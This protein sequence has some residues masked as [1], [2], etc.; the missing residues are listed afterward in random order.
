M[1]TFVGCR[2]RGISTTYI[3]ASLCRQVP[4][5]PTGYLVC[6][7]KLYLVFTE[8][9]VVDDAV[10]RV[11]FPIYNF[12]DV[13]AGPFCSWSSSTRKAATKQCP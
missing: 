2:I 4:V 1:S 13:A 12:V 6:L 8:K 9:L 3:L 5:A 11:G 10:R 7:A